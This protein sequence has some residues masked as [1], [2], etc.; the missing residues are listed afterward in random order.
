MEHDTSIQ[1]G[2]WPAT[3]SLAVARRLERTGAPWRRGLWVTARVSY[4]P[5]ELS[6]RFVVRTIELDGVRRRLAHAQGDGRPLL[7]LPGL[8][9]TLDEGLFSELA[10]AA[11]DG[12]REVLL[13][14][15]RCAGPT[16]ALNA[17][18]AVGLRRQGAELA[19]LLSALQ[20]HPDVLAL[21]A[22]AAVALSTPNG[23][24]GRMAAWSATLD[25]AATAARVQASPILRGYYRRVMRRAW[26]AASRPPPELAE[27]WSVLTTDPVPAPQRPTLLVHTVDDPVAPVEA[28]AAME[29]RPGV[30]VRLLRCGGHL[31]FS[32]VDG[33]EVYLLPFEG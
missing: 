5:R 4:R 30:A 2:A 3:A 18:R 28:V 14:E 24:L 9:A 33:V 6:E 31:G 12:G 10:D 21:S 29:G 20:V 27:F 11:T 1:D 8:H 16:L 25:P 19:G 15:D 7:I 17:G 32:A 26:A 22:G 13:L 23:V